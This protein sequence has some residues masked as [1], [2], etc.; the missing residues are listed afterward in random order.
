MHT[1]YKGDDFL[2]AVTRFKCSRKGITVLY[3]FAFASGESV[4]RQHGQ[5]L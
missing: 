2:Q 1:V 3:H 4:V 5:S